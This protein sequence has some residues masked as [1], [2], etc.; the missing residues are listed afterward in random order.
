MNW[1][2]LRGEWGAVT[3]VLTVVAGMIVVPLALY[4]ANVTPGAVTTPTISTTSSA[5][6]SGVQTASPARTSPSPSPSPSH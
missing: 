2:V 3:F 6:A 1:G 5:R 4:F